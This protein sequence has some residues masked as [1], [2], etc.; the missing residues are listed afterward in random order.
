MSPRFIAV[1][2]VLSLVHALAPRGIIPTHRLPVLGALRSRGVG[3]L[4]RLA[5]AAS[6]CALCGDEEREFDPG[7]AARLPGRWAPEALCGHCG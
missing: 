5:L 3:R 2:V 4:A 6:R 1:P 7:S